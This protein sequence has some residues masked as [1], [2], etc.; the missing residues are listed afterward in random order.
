MYWPVKRRDFITLLG[1]TAAAW[2]FVASAQ[3]A[4][5]VRRVGVLIPLAMDDP[6]AK[7]RIAAFQQGLEQLGWTD[8]GNVRSIPD[9]PGAIW[10]AFANMRWNWSRSLL[11][12]SWPLAAQP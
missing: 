4:E 10:R 8:G 12:S 2:P 3:P 6:E 11:M 5:R 7:A 1:S 9:G